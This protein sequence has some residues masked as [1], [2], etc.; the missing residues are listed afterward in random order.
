MRNHE[1]RR[2]IRIVGVLSLIGI[3]AVLVHQSY[4]VFSK[5]RSELLVDR[6]AAEL[7]EIEF[8]IHAAPG[9]ALLFLAGFFAKK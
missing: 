8:W 9:F 3:A 6:S 5:W 1:L 2:Y 4:F 7:S